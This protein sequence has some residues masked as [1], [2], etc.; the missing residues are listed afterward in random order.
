MAARKIPI[1]IELVIHF[2][3]VHNFYGI[4]SLCPSAMKQLIN[5]YTV[6]HIINFLSS[7]IV[8]VRSG[9]RIFE[10]NEVCCSGAV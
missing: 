6:S 4:K 8:H 1:I 5:H 7:G 2:V 10:T 9:S 3:N